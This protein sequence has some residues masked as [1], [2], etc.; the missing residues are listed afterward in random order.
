MR[1]FVLNHILTLAFVAALLGM[2]GLAILVGIW[3]PRGAI[4]MLAAF[5]GWCIG[6][7]HGVQADVLRERENREP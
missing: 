6:L 1:K 7:F 2:G 3:P 4:I 5:C